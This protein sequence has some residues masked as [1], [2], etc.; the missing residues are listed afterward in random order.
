[1]VVNEIAAALVIRPG[2]RVL[3]A[4]PDPLPD[5]PTPGAVL[6]DLQ[7]RFPGVEFTIICG[8]TAMAKT[9]SEASG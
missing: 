2:D 4:M 5:D 1:M 3:L 8:V 9:E 6:G 7:A